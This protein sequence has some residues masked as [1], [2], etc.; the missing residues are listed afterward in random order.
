MIV[1][2]THAWVFYVSEPESLSKRARRRIEKEIAKR[3]AWISAMSAWEV[4][5]LAARGRL[6][7]S[8]AVEDWIARA[9]SVPGLATVP[10]DT[11]VAVRSVT[12][13]A[14]YPADPADR[15]I[16]ATALSLGADLVTKD[17]NLRRIDG[18]PTVW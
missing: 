2:D 5:M 16:A 4:A 17:R 6:R 18:L 10:V 14:G 8:V 11:N 15:I 12:L 9:E 1:L 13:P 7:L 3:D